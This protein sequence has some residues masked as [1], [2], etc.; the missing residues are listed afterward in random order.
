MSRYRNFGLFL[1]LAA[2]WGSAFMAIKAGLSYFPPVPFAA[3]RYDI[4]GVFMLGYALYAT[5]RWLPRERAEVA[6]VSVGGVMIIAGYHTFLFVGEQYTTSAVAAVIVSLSPI[7]TTG[8]ARLFLPSES[9][10]FK[11]VIG[12]LLGLVGVGILAHPDPSNLLTSDIVGKAIVLGAP[13]CFAL[14]SVLTRRVE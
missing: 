9:L 8:F 7:L 4:A 6:L 14:G 10:T 12:L 3:I 13:V 11:G 5:D 2:V 1:V